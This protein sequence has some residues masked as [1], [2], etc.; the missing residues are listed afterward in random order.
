M[1]LTA[2][3]R[4]FIDHYLQTWNATEAARLA[5]YKGN[6]VTLGSVGWENLQKPQIKAE[7][8]KRLD[9]YAMSANEVLER[10]SRMARGFDMTKYVS[11]ED[12]YAINKDGEEYLV[13]QVMNL[14]LDALQRDGYSHLVKKIKQ[15]SSG[16][17]VEWHDQ[18]AALVHIGKHH[19]LFTEKV[20]LTTGG[21][22]LG[23]S[24]LE[25]L[26]KVYDD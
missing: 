12:K 11:F 7:I 3:Q 9:Q 17:E 8:E 2:K 16:I 6:E 23:E 19:G 13:G 26:D 5:G 1:K 10:L 14:D 21:K 24:L 18:M 20:D 22:P 25:A 4:L 15:T